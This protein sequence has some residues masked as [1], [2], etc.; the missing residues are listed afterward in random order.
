MK[1]LKNRFYPV[2]AFIF[3]LMIVSFGS[4]FVSSG[5]PSFSKQEG[6]IVET[7]NQYNT[8]IK[9]SSLKVVA[10]VNGSN[11][12]LSEVLR[13]EANDKINIK[14]NLLY[15]ETAFQ[16]GEID[17]VQ[18]K[19]LVSEITNESNAKSRKDILDILIRNELLY[20]E[21]INLGYIVTV[22]E[23]YQYELSMDS[24]M[25][26]TDPK[27]YLAYNNYTETLAISFGMAYDEY[28]RAFVVPVRQKYLAADLLINDQLKKKGILVSQV[29]LVG[30]HLNNLYTD[31]YN[32]ARIVEFQ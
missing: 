22:E 17:Q 1:L 15:A 12:Y 4:M 27:G 6:I 5:T 24:K 28:I 11:I 21:A 14:L 30:E 26:T 18:Y 13:L 25:K 2:L 7:M 9:E 8:R 19:D 20:Q 10:S 32:Q 29:D 23:A 3:L 31:L 16:N